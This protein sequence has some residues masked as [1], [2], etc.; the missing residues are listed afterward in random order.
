MLLYVHRDHNNYQEQGV[1]DGHLNFHV[2]PSQFF[3][4]KKKKKGK[5]KNKKTD[6][7]LRGA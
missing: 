7:C 1:Q 6:V 5:K 2:A 4:K 3:K